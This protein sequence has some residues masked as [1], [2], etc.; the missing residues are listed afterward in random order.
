M[1]SMSK[2]ASDRITE[3]VSAAEYRTSAE[4]KVIVLSYCW[5]DIRE[6]AES[7]FYKYELHETQDRNA[8]MILLVLVNHEFLV[9]GDKGIHEKVEEDFWSTVCS[10][11]R[12]KFQAGNLVDGL[13]TGV[14]RVGD[15][16]ATYFPRAEDDVNEVTDEVV[17]ED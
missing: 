14:E 13:C 16:L 12:E 10:A 3:A 11:M 15:Q 1:N 5:T 2:E 7:L 17:H 6:K 9:Y 8:V 4:I